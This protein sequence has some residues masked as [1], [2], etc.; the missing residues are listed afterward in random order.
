MLH[1]VIFLLASGCGTLCSYV[2]REYYLINENKKWDDAQS[3][4]R[5]NYTDLATIGSHDD[6]KKLVNMTAA[7]GETKEIWIGLKKN[8][9]ASWLWSVGETQTSDG[10]AVYTNWASLPDSSHYCGGMRDD[11]KW[12][13]ASCVETHPFVCQEVES[14]RMYVVLEEKT[15]SQAQLHC[16]QNNHDLVSVKNQAEN[17][18]LQQTVGPSLTFF[19]TGVFRDEWKWSDK[20]N[21]SFRMW[22][23]SQPNNDGVCTLYSPS[24]KSWW[25]RNCDYRYPFICYNATERNPQTARYFLRVEIQSNSFSSF[26]DSAMSEAILNEIQKRYEGLKLR[27]RVQPDGKIFHQKEKKKEE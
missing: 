12:L 21:S 15:W 9:V 3:Y 6:L 11:G 19:W 17:Q 8:G 10:L 1:L 26:S 5:E 20:S 22:E 27:W 24:S 13:S 23:S 2:T 14:S 4:C 18:A 25:D 7:S 16:R